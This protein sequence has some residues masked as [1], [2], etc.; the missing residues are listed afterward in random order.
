MPGRGR[1][2]NALGD[3][4][5][6]GEGIERLDGVKVQIDTATVELSNSSGHAH[7]AVQGDCSQG[8]GGQLLWAPILLERGRDLH[9]RAILNLD[10]GKDQLGALDSSSLEETLDSD[11]VALDEVSGFGSTRKLAWPASAKLREDIV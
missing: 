9:R 3:N 7:G 2:L 8:L 10:V 4:D 11:L 5:V 6:L 1:E